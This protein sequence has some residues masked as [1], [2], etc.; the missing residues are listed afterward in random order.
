VAILVKTGRPE[1][2]VPLGSATFTQFVC[3]KLGYT[4]IEQGSGFFYFSAKPAM[5]CLIRAQ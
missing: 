2:D 3:V 1:P 5:I 4:F